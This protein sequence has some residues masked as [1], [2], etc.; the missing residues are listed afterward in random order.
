MVAPGLH[1]DGAETRAARGLHTRPQHPD[2]VAHADQDQPCRIQPEGGK[3]RRIKRARLP[4]RMGLAYPDEVASRARRRHGAQGKACAKARS[5]GG[6][7]I[8][9]RQDFV[10]AAARQPAGKRIVNQSQAEAKSRLLPPG[11]GRVK[12]C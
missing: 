9:C 12:G 2:H 10:Q 11:S 8:G 5:S 3:S 6:I 4:L 7:G 1:D